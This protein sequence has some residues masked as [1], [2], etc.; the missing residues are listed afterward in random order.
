M[1]FAPGTERRL[2]LTGGIMFGT[3]LVIAFTFRRL[4]VSQETLS[5]VGGSFAYAFLA[6]AAV[7]LWQGWRRRGLLVEPAI[8]RFLASQPAVAQAVGTPITLEV[9]PEAQ[10]QAR[11]HAQANLSVNVSGPE[12]AAVAD[13]VMARLGREWE[14]LS[15]AL[16]RDGHRVR[17]QA[18]APG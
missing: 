6:A 15:G 3:F 13:L 12:G 17:L 14:V 5:V 2:M 7:I 4:D 16:V 8:T 18:G 1:R 9:P 10:R 11:G